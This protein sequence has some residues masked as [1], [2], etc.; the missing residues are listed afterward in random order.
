M[1]SALLALIGVT[2]LTGLAPPAAAQTVGD[3]ADARCILVMTLAARD[4]KNREAAQ[5][6][7]YY[8]LG[9]LSGHSLSAKLAPIMLAEGKGITNAAQAQAELARCGQEMNTRTAELRAT[10][11]QMQ[12]A[13]QAAQ[14]AGPHAPPP[15]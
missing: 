11:V 12:Q 6:A 9:K 4:P 1:R 7:S 15:K 10:M 13:A 8:F 5:E 3:K 14:P 2:A